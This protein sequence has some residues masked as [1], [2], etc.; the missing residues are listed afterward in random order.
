MRQDHVQGLASHGFYRLAYREWGDADNPRV[1]FCVHGLTR[2]AAD[3]D[4]LAETLAPRMRVVAVDLPGRGDSDWLPVKTDYALPTYLNAC[5]TLLA[6]LNVR[7]VDW[8]GT[9]LGGLVGMSLAALPGSPIARLIL[10][11]IGPVMPAAPLRRIAAGV[12]L[13]GNFADLE[14]VEA[15]LRLAMATFGVRE[16]AHWRHL[17]VSSSRPD[18]KGGLRLHYDPGI[19][20]VFND[21]KVLEGAELWPLWEMIHCPVLLLRGAESDLLTAADAQAMTRRGPKATLVEFPGC[22]HAPPLM[23]AGQIAALVDWLT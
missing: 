15:Y 10:N 3:F 6:R 1:L 5:A 16:D 7:Q 17:A 18:G 9:S 19:A 13:G 22:G 11:D 8:L 2:N 12:G 23:E 20:L 4:L 21:P 14:A